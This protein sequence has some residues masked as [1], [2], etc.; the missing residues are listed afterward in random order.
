MESDLSFESE[1]LLLHLHFVPGV[2][3]KWGQRVILIDGLVFFHQPIIGAGGHKDKP[4]DGVMLGGVDEGPD[5]ISIDG[6]TFVGVLARDRIAHEA[7]QDNDVIYALQSLRDKTRITNVAAYKLVARMTQIRP[8]TALVFIYELIQATNAPTRPQEM[9]RDHRADVTST[10][11]QQHS[12]LFSCHLST[13]LLLKNL[14]GDRIVP[15]L[16][17]ALAAWSPPS[18]ATEQRFPYDDPSGMSD[19]IEIRRDGSIRVICQVDFRFSGKQNRPIEIRYIAVLREQSVFMSEENLA[20][21]DEAWPV[22]EE[23]FE[24]IS[25]TV[26]K[27]ERLGSWTD[28]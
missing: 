26:G 16:Y 8:R 12:S 27:Y 25:E 28:E 7:C 23:L 2:K 3:G 15:W 21:S 5:A 11:Y 20:W 18:H 14:R 1:D 19:P 9:A 4:V 6:V 24:S 13:R 17:A 10:T 22:F